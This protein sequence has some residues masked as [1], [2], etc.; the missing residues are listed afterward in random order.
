MEPK[1]EYEIQPETSYRVIRKVTGE[2]YTGNE[3]LGLYDTEKQAQDA[4]DAMRLND[5]IIG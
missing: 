1:I 4:I 3:T 2:R 5:E